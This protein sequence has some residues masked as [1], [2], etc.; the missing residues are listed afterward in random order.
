MMAAFAAAEVIVI[1]LRILLQFENKRRRN[2]GVAGHV[3]DSEYM[4]LTDKENPEFKVCHRC[5][6]L[7]P[8][9]LR[10]I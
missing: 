5:F 7:A 6:H 4:N 2:T 8:S 10:N 1:I 3:K 9:D